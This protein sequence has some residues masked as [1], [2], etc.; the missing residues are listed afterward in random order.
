MRLY[1]KF[2]ESF[3]KI[4]KPEEAYSAVGHA[5]NEFNYEYATVVAPAAAA[6]LPFSPESA[7]FPFGSVQDARHDWYSS[8]GS[9]FPSVEPAGAYVAKHEPTSA[10]YSGLTSSYDW[11]QP[12]LTEPVYGVEPAGAASSGY[13]SGTAPT[14]PVAAGAISPFSP[15]QEN[16]PLSSLGQQ[17]QQQHHPLEIEDALNVLKTHMV[18]DPAAKVGAHHQYGLGLEN[19][20]PLLGQ[21]STALVKRK[22]D[23][24][25]SGLDDLEDLKPS[26]SDALRASAGSRAARSKR[27]RKSEEA[28][29]AEDASMDP[30]EKDK[31]DKERRWA[32]NQRERVRIRDIN[33][34]LK[35][36]GRIC[37]SHQK[38]DKPMTKLG[39]LNNAVDVIMA[40]EQQ[41]R[42]RNLNPK[43]ACLKRREESGPASAAS[44]LSPSPGLVGG[45]HLGSSTP[46]YS[47]YS[48][49]GLDG[50]GS[51]PA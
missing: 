7:Y 20:Q 35:E 42:E 38:S 11:Q 36:L 34:A 16:L 43:V 14:T 2:N 47:P 17:Q 18:S 41:V 21:K 44:C 31:K 1:Q 50:G 27:S 48:P 25:D 22:F 30:E 40:L 10:G 39:I 13:S 12:F 15:R 19:E 8:A 9:E 51:F 29:D 24:L 32:N 5:S 3:N 28:Q 4:A 23:G 26:S 33:D 49:T 45:A 37:S 46:G 6:A